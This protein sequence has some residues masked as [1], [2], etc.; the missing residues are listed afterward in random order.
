MP[1][2]ALSMGEVWV[3][4]NHLAAEAGIEDSVDSGYRYLKRLSMDY[5]S[6]AAILQ[7]S[8]RVHTWIEADREN[9]AIW[10]LEA[11]CASGTDTALV[12]L[13]GCGSLLGKDDLQPLAAGQ[14]L[15]LPAALGPAWCQPQGGPLGLLVATLPEAGRAAA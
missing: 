9:W 5:G 8:S 15:L 12:V 4:G 13:H 11:F 1:V 14:T 7:L 2:T 10:A 3:A 6:D